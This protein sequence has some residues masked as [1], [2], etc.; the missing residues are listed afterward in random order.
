[1]INVDW[2][3]AKSFVAWLSVQTGQRYRLLSEAEWEYACR[4][5]T[6]TRYWWGEE[7]TREDANYDRNIGKTSEVGVYP[8]NSWGLCDTHGNVWEWVEDCW[9]GTYEQAPPDGS[10]WVQGT[11][12]SRVVRGGSWNSHPRDLRAAC[13]NGHSKH[14]RD[15]G[16]G[17]RVARKLT[18]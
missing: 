15:Y 17:F 8:A 16:I 13:R 9:N 14:R 5:C 7:I 12:S 10:A 3:D 11:A 4:A 2:E 18:Y 6:T 1:M